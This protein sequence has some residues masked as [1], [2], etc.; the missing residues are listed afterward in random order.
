MRL[1]GSNSRLE[2]IYAEPPPPLILS[3]VVVRAFPEILLLNGLS[4]Q[5]LRI[6]DMRFIL[7]MRNSSHFDANLSEQ[8]Q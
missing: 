6:P 1:C 7:L 8:Y 5:P 4:V 2:N 3:P